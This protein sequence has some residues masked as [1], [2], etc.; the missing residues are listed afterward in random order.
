M[1]VLKNNDTYHIQHRPRRYLIRIFLFTVV[2]MLLIPACQPIATD[3][4]ATPASTKTAD[5]KPNP[6]QSALPVSDGPLLLLQS[7]VDAYHFIDIKSKT[8]TPLIFPDGNPQINLRSSLSPGGLKL[9]ISDSAGGLYIYSLKTGQT[10]PLNDLQPDIDAFS[11]EA[12]AQQT[13]QDV[14]MHDYSD[15]GL[16]QSIESAFNASITNIRWHASDHHLL[17]VSR[18]TEDSTHLSLGDIESGQTTQLENLPGL[19]EDYWLAPDGGTILLKKGYVFDPGVWQDDRY[20]LVNL[21]DGTTAAIPLPT[22]IQKPSI[23]WF[24]NDYIGVI[25]Q[26]ELVGG[27]DFSLITR[28]DLKTTLVVPGDF[29]GVYAFSS[30]IL[31]LHNDPQNLNTTLMVRTPNGQVVSSQQIDGR[32]T[33]TASVD[34]H[35]IL[36]NCEQDSILIEVAELSQTPFGLPI[37]IFAQSPSRERVVLIN[38]NG[39]ATLLNGALKNRQELNL[40]GDPLEILWLPDSSGFLYRTARHLYHHDLATAVNHQLLMSD[41][42]GDYRNLNAVWIQP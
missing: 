25:H 39:D 19:V 18:V 38:R 37:F 22:T 5:I 24:S 8:T 41:F 4:L 6:T 30:H 9:L 20:Y 33:M 27:Q 7:D 35:R 3:T 17:L 12:A 14:I 36:L 11:P 31:S 23:F 34:A 16:L 2:L 13:A 29:T 28:Q 15:E 10:Q 1:P 40:A 42:F 21:D 32:C 26:R